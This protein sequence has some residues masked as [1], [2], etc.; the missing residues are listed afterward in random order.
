M[1]FPWFTPRR[2]RPPVTHAPL[3]PG[4]PWPSF[5]RGRRPT[6]AEVE[7]ILGHIAPRPLPERD[8]GP[9]RIY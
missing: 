6:E 4:Y 5:P 1:R 7:A 2:D 8:R 9:S 3:H